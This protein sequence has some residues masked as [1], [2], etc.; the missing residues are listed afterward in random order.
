MNLLSQSCSSG[1]DA[2]STPV[3][4]ADWGQARHTA[5]WPYA[6]D[7][8]SG[9]GSTGSKGMCLYCSPYFALAPHSLSRPRQSKTEHRAAMPSPSLCHARSLPLLH[10]FPINRANSSALFRASTSTPL[11]STSILGRGT[12]CG[13]RHW[14]S[15]RSVAELHARRGQP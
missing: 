5:W 2:V 7:G 12:F 11:P 6:D 8:Q 1:P 14:C 15:R 13:F 9:Q 4:V 3:S 10:H